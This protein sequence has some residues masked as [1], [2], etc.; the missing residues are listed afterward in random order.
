MSVAGGRI[1]LLESPIL[2]KG[3]QMKYAFRRLVAG[4]VITP[5]VAVVYLFVYAGLVGLGAEP[6][7]SASEVWTNGLWLGA[8]VSL[9]FAGSAL[10]K[11]GK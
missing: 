10:V 11:A 3:K 4:V 8:F 9:A 7:A 6:T 2:R 5:L 1:V